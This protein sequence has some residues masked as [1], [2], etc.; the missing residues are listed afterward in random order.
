MSDEKQ[1]CYYCG[2]K[3]TRECCECE[4][5]TCKDCTKFLSKEM[6]RYH[7]KPPRVFQYTNLCEPCFE[8]DA[9]PHLD[10]YGEVEAKAKE[11]TLVPD[12]YRGNV[13]CL[14]RVQIPVTVKKHDDEFHATSHLRFLAAWEGYDAIVEF[15]T[16]G[17]QKRN[18]GWQTT[19]WSAK[20]NFANLNHKR[21]QKHNA[22]REPQST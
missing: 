3:A 12:S 1:E 6:V 2:R 8:R 14:K 4:K 22:R 5:P 17:Q 15:S 20:G 13:P 19:S 11:V 10:K 21:F 7:P 9:Q 18:A 16:D